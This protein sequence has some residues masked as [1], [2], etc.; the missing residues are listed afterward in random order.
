LA[1]HFLIG[2]QF[3]KTSK[4]GHTHVLR[5]FGIL[6]GG[7]NFTLNMCVFYAKPI[8][9]IGAGFEWKPS[10]KFGFGFEGGICFLITHIN[11]R[12]EGFAGFMRFTTIFYWR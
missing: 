4:S 11:E 1:A 9:N 3:F 2:K 8:A 10:Q 5:P 12:G 6:G 7:M